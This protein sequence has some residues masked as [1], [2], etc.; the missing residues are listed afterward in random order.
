MEAIQSKSQNHWNKELL[1]WMSELN[2][3]LNK[4]YS[5][6]QLAPLLSH[7]NQIIQTWEKYKE[8][9]CENELDFLLAQKSWWTEYCQIQEQ[10]FQSFLVASVKTTY[11]DSKKLLPPSIQLEIFKNDL[12]KE[13]QSLWRILWQWLFKR[14]WDFSNLIGS[15][16]NFM[17]KFFFKYSELPLPRYYRRFNLHLCLDHFFGVPALQF[18]H[19]EVLL[20]QKLNVEICDRIDQAIDF[21]FEKRWLPTQTELQEEVSLELILKNIRKEVEELPASLS[22]KSTNWIEENSAIFNHE[23]AFLG[24]MAIPALFHNAK[25]VS[26]L[27]HHEW[28]SINTSHDAWKPYWAARLDDLQIDTALMILGA[29]A[30]VLS[31]SGCERLT[32]DHAKPVMDEIEKCS[33]RIDQLRQV[34][35][36][37]FDVK[38]FKKQIRIITQEIRFQLLPAIFKESR[39]HHPQKQLNQTLAALEST[40]DQFPQKTSLLF[41]Q[42]FKSPLPKIK[43]KELGFAEIIQIEVFDQ[44]QRDLIEFLEEE[45]QPFETLLRDLEQLDQL[46][47]INLN[48]LLL[49]FQEKTPFQ[50]DPDLV[51]ASFN[52]VFESL[53]N[54]KKID[55]ELRN[56]SQTFLMEQQQR[57]SSHAL[58][59]LDNEKVLA[60]QLKLAQL[61]ARERF[62]EYRLRLL[63]LALSNW[64]KLKTKLEYYGKKLSGRANYFK[65]LIG[66]IQA[67]PQE[68]RL[69]TLV[70][71]I[72]NK[73]NKLPFVYRHIFRN[74]PLEDDRF[75]L[76]RNI[77]LE[78]VQFSFEQ[79]LKHQHGTLAI[80]G[81][82][83]AG[84]SSLWM[85]L[86]QNLFKKYPTFNIQIDHTCLV[87]SQLCQLFNDSFQFQSKN[88]KELEEEILKR[89]QV[90]I[91]SLENLDKLFLRVHGGFDLLKGL[92]LL[93]HRT[94]R[95]VFWIDFSST[96]SWEYL[97]QIMHVSHQFENIIQ[98]SAPS[99]VE[100]EELIMQRHSLSGFQLQFE[101]NPEQ[102]DRKK[103]KKLHSTQEI[104]QQLNE[105]FFEDLYN[106]SGGNI[107]LA[108]FHWIRS[109]ESTLETKI[110]F[111]NSLH[112]NTQ[113]LNQLDPMEIYTLS[114]ILLHDHLTVE[115]VAQI[116]RI[117]LQESQIRLDLLTEKGIVKALD[118]SYQVHPLFYKGLVH[119]LKAKNL[120]Q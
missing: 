8:G 20:F 98:L 101:P 97:D 114:A 41:Y 30:H 29:K 91:V 11:E 32:E 18:W 40:L 79:Y 104:F 2:T 118:H 69:K 36:S 48:S 70:T 87:E 24:T 53:S 42:N 85:I 119:L 73:I 3:T 96:L 68:L 102:K 99:I 64:P 4:D 76:A 65:R 9:S 103:F 19:Q 57:I 49:Q 108:L 77:E 89:D 106:L 71:D 63:K 90:A 23:F 111:Q 21:E 14:Q 110:V 100:I 78:Q 61:R 56:K 112:W 84:K 105:E 52:R 25:Q 83:G 113:S 74:S 107:G 109:V 82:K 13:S 26:S 31:E 92:I 15:L 17:R 67:T 88:L 62:R 120:L 75:F 94:Q 12:S 37:Q 39:E 116:F 35:L 10:G 50:V 60:I 5:T 80:V 34:I 115:E 43:T 58:K 93:Q 44:I 33:Q 66:L 16:K 28:Q 72:Q 81:E 7:I 6:K 46:M 1:D 55:A 59:L 51:N 95:K 45:V 27:I 38:D 54:L 117:T 47:D 22:I 86:S